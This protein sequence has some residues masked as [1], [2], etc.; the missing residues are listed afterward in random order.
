[1]MV[2]EPMNEKSAPTVAT[3]SP[4][5]VSGE[6]KA[7]KRRDSSKRASD[8]LK[9][10]TAKELKASKSES[11]SR[12]KSPGRLSKNPGPPTR[13]L[14]RK[15]SS[16]MGL[17]EKKDKKKKKI[18]KIA[19]EEGKKMLNV[20]ASRKKPK[21]KGSKMAKKALQDGSN[22][23]EYIKNNEILGGSEHTQST[24]TSDSTASTKDT[25]DKGVSKK[26]KKP[27]EKSLSKKGTKKKEKSSI[28]K[29]EKSSSASN[30]PKP[31]PTAASPRNRLLSFESIHGKSIHKPKTR[32]SRGNSEAAGADNYIANLAPPPPPSPQPHH[33]VL[34]SPQSA[35][36]K[37]KSVLKAKKEKQEL[38][39]RASLKKST[40]LRTAPSKNKEDYI[41]EVL[42]I[43]NTT[44]RTTPKPSTHKT[45]IHNKDDFIDPDECSSQSSS[46]SIVSDGSYEKDDLLSHASERSDERTATF[47]N[48][49]S[50]LDENPSF[51]EH[52]ITIDADHELSPTKLSPNK[53]ALSMI[54][55]SDAH[56][57]PEDTTSRD[58][59]FKETLME[60]MASSMSALTEVDEGESPMN[61]PVASAKRKVP[62]K[63]LLK[64]IPESAFA[65][66]EEVKTL[67]KKIPESAFSSGGRG[68]STRSVP[69]R[70]QSDI[71]SLNRMSNNILEIRLPGQRKT[72]TRQRSLTFN[73]KVRVKRVPCQAQ[74][75][76]GDT[77]DLWF[78]PQ[79]YDAIKRKTMALIRAVQDDQTGG[80]TY[81]TRGLERYF[82][83][84]AV[85]EKRNDAWDSVLDEQE[86]QRSNQ[87]AFSAERLSM[88][89]S[90]TT[91][92]SIQEATE[93]G[94]LDQDA[95]ARYTK[96]MRQTLRRTYS[97]AV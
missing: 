26:G 78:Q 58:G 74:V 15:S 8:S 6:K 29:K 59:S 2:I 48:L 35:G 95:I 31:P 65:L 36:T 46:C 97:N 11:R 88:A 91:R 55:P 9:R 83:V 12:S 34:S 70:A 25:S 47:E 38:Q 7:P 14:S 69:K 20:I 57:T 93:R 43:V 32:R 76:G 73:E 16:K 94:K 23:A 80:V 87:E 39:R 66:A 10:N 18:K 79:E 21:R 24:K 45:I 67:L 81:C 42:D 60:A 13:S 3:A 1:M 61:S 64:K 77:S 82:S 85:Q 51:G 54:S 71:T 17:K 92:N 27:L 50:L 52:S 90:Q 96:K 30:P 4:K 53:I 62:Q 56:F 84:D 75:C 28:K 33:A 89:Y 68:P 41:H 19:S 63:T 49:G 44:P 5:L 86:A 37:K 72:I 40:S 22:V